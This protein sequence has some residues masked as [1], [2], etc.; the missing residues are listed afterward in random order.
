MIATMASRG[1]RSGSSS[2]SS[3]SAAAKPTTSTPHPV[4]PIHCAAPRAPG[5]VADGEPAAPHGKPP[6]G[7]RDRANSKSAQPPTATTH[8]RDA[9]HS[10]TTYMSKA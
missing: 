1:R 3:T 4:G 9:D 2:A 10:R 7:K 5:M 6:R 8:H